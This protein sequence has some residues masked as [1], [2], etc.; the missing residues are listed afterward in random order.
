M[1]R[2]VR[3]AISRVWMTPLSTGG[4]HTKR[5]PF[6]GALTLF[7]MRKIPAPNHEG[8]GIIKKTVLV[9]IESQGIHNFIASGFGLSVTT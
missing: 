8:Q 4:V 5:A 9:L 6:G 2:E 1:N 7:N 3:R